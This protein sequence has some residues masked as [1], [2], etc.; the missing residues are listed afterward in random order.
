MAKGVLPGSKDYFGHD[1][2]TPDTPSWMQAG[3]I[4]K[5]EAE[6]T[7][8][9]QVAEKALAGNS[10]GALA[11]LVGAKLPTQQQVQMK[12]KYNAKDK[13]YAARAVGAFRNRVASG[14][15]GKAIDKLGRR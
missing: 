12:A 14:D 7:Y 11:Q 4:A 2:A 6:Q 5:Y 15:V 10:A 1:I 13:K 9:G 8:P 3:Q